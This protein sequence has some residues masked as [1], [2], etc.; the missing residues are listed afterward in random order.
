MALA[1]ADAER[2]TEFERASPEALG[3]L[4]LQ[5]D[6]HAGRLDRAT[7]LAAVSDALADGIAAAGNLRA[8]FPASGPEQIARELGLPVETTDDDPMVGSIWRFAEYRPRPPRIV[9]YR[10][11]LS[12]LERVLTGSRAVQLLGEATPRDIFIAHELYHHIESTR[13][14]VPIARR[15]QPTLFRIGNWHWRT[16]I[17]ALAEIAAGAF[18]QALLE[19]PCHPKALD[20]V[21]LH[22]IAV[23]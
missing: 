13:P 22:A 4:M 9:L 19:L 7:Q 23:T 3:L 16:G 20:F 5:A 8:R 17:A 15:Y 18:A 14:D 21:V 12:P 1:A 11:G 2:F 10:R 6:P